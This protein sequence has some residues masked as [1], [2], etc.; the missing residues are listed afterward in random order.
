MPSSPDRILVIKLS[1]LGD[2][3]LSVASFQAIR[4]HHR[5]AAIALL[6]TAPYRRLAEASGCFDAII[7]DPRPAWWQPGRWLALR[8]Q[9]AD[10]RFE[11]VYDLQRSDRSGSY[12]RLLPRPKPEWVGVVPGCSHRYRPPADRVL[13]I[14]EREAA[15]LALAGV[16]RPDLP[17]LGFLTADL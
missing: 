8:R 4:A 1:A 6:T 10:G 3:V 14:C 9:L 7:V 12:F 5:E 13:H 11:R 17:D 15:Q 2:F 16:P